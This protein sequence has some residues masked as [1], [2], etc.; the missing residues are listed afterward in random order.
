[1]ISGFATSEGTKNFLKNSGITSLNFK[2]IHNLTLS[3]VGVGTYLGEATPTL[4]N[5]RL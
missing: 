1:M 2:Q 5:V 4:D 3:N